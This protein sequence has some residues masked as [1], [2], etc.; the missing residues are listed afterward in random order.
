MVCDMQVDYLIDLNPPNIIA[1][2][3]TFL[4]TVI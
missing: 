4:I 2:L 1:F 3:K